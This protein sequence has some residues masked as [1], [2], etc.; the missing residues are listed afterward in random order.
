MRPAARVA[1]VLGLAV[2][3]SSCGPSTTEAPPP[4]SAE[5]RE[6]AYSA[7][8]VGVALLEQLHYNEAA[9]AFQEALKSD[10]SL[11]I[12]R[13]NLSLAFLYEQDFAGA[14][15]EATEAARL[16]PSAPQ[17]PYVLGLIARAQSRND[18]AR[19]HFEHVRQLDPR[20]VGASVNVAQIALEDRRY[21]DAIAALRPV[22]AV[23]PYHVTA[24]YVLGLALTRAGQT[25]EGQPLLER[26]QSLR[27]T[28]YAVT[29]GTG[30][31]EQGRYA[32]AIASTGAEPDLVD[33]ETSR[34]QFSPSGLVAGM[35]GAASVESP[36][37]RRFGARM[38]DAVGARSIAAGL[39]GG[40][41]LFD[42]DGDGDLDLF[43]AGERADRLLRNDG[44][45][46]ADATAG[47]GF[48]QPAS[49]SVAIGAV[50]AD[51]D[52]DGAA[53]LFV[54]RFGGSRLYRNNGKG[55]FA[56]VSR[57]ARL[58]AF[59]YLPGAA[60]FVDVDHDGDVDLLVAGLADIDGTR[61]GAG[62]GD[63]LFPAEFAPAPLQLLRNNRDGTFTDVTRDAK[64]ASRGHAVAIVPTD[65]DNR[66]DLDLL[67]VNADAPPVLYANQR[68][69]T[70]KNTAQE[71]GL[72]SVVPPAGGLFTTA[73]AGDVNKDDWPDVFFGSTGAGV[74]AVSD[75]RGRFSVGP[76]PAGS[77]GTAAAQL[78]DYDADGLLDLVAW[79][80]D[81]PR[82]ARNLGREW[83]DVSAA[84][85]SAGGT[86]GAAD[87]VAPPLASPRAL[88]MADVDKDGD[89]DLIVRRGG[90]LTIWRNG[91][92]V[93]HKTLAVD[94]RGLVSNRLGIGAK[95]QARAGSLS[96]RVEVSAAS[97]AVAPADVIFG[98]GARSGADVV[99]VLWPSGILQ[100]EAAAGAATASGAALLPSPFRIE[101][102]DRKPSSCP[103]LFTWNGERFEF[104]TDFLGGGEMGDWQAPGLFNRPD[105]VEYVRIRGDQ[106]KVRDG[107]FELRVTNELEEAL[108]L[109]HLQ[110]FSVGHPADVQIFPNEG[111]TDP[112]KP[113]V[114]QAVRDLQA[115]TRVVDDHG[116][117]VGARVARIDRTYPDDFSLAPIRGYA[118]SHALTIDV[119]P[120]GSD[121]RGGTVLLLT[122]WTDYAFSSDNVAAQQAGLPFQVPT[123]D[124]RTPSGRWRPL[125]VPVGFPVGRPQ[126]IAVDLSRALR[127]GEHELRLTTTMRIYWDQ[128][129]VGA[130]VPSVDLRVETMMPRTAVLGERGFSAEVRPDG[131]NPPVYDYDRVTRES[132]WKAFA[133]AFTRTGDVRPLLDHAD[134]QF[135]IARTG[136]ELALSFDASALAP[137]P[138]GWTRTFLLRGDGFSKEMDINSAT[139][140]TVEPLPFH[141]MSAYPYPAS[142][143]YPE[144]PEHNRYREQYNTRRVTRPL[145][146]LGGTR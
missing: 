14:E 122:G 15:R 21:E 38:L 5:A 99:R 98:L 87:N 66:R 54:M 102:L 134:D 138:A 37:G 104:I 80:A 28:G 20:D 3:L 77:Q 60:A 105:P 58:P 22:V 95:V 59:P 69:G 17:P 72:A 143:R 133:G 62:A 55:R 46:W 81:A 78:V 41:T 135:V 74:L 107:R 139:P 76:A 2:F 65:I 92:D 23:E 145:P 93:R 70:F 57:S 120:T 83:R 73:A 1:L 7:N 56:D 79:S 25:E 48:E 36:F 126:T 24:S 51:F 129:L 130:A 44:A 35:T 9:T 114:I 10:A 118:A 18:V 31:L 108:F 131:H 61:R 27:R 97:P 89:T 86:P 34:A 39:G 16:L 6:R 110:L 116:R 101:E 117:D 109:D 141:G 84:A 85:V 42:A 121:A 67:I 47:S 144:T 30:Y 119:S 100:A 26:A 112:A 113:F 123:L 71:I 106:L 49:G 91:G 142:E 52:N 29:F 75:G 13:L 140:H 125:D 82:V 103:F 111:L 124:V 136:D 32:E 146:S 11:A 64:L 68:D 94:L 90:V 19:G 12:A 63:R 53:D 43:V 96:A 127:A 132:P 137:L 8:N 50:S 45:S 4:A 115:P 33:A 40:V 128:I 88:A